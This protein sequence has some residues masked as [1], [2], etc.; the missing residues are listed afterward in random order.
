MIKTSIVLAILTGLLVAHLSDTEMGL[1]ML[2]FSLPLYI[3]YTGVG[4]RGD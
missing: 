4:F 1:R 3:H 2:V